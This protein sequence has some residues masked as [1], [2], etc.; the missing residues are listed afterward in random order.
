[1]GAGCGGNVDDAAWFTILDTEVWGSLSDQPERSGVVHRENGIPL[2]IGD[3][4]DD[5]I[6]GITGIV[7][8]DMNLSISKLCRL[9]D[10]NGEEVGVGD[11]ASNGNSSTGGGVVD[12]LGNAVGFGGVDISHHNFG[13]LVGEESGGLGAD[14]LTGAGDLW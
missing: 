12:R 7:D 9:L 6:P 4:M 8:N 2:L 1:M 14:T 11:I 3:F 13:T 5:T 10:Q